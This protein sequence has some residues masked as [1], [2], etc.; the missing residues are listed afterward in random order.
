MHK[1]NWNRLLSADRWDGLD[2]KAQKK[3]GE[4][5]GGSSVHDEVR[6]FQDDTE[7]L[8]YSSAFR[9]MQ[10][11]T[12]V[13]PLPQ[14]DYY[15]TR[16]THSIE[17]AQVGRLIAVAVGRWLAKKH[18]SELPKHVDA[19]DI[20]DIVYTACLAHDIGNPPFGHNGEEAIQSWFETTAKNEV[21]S[22]V[23]D[24]KNEPEKFCDFSSF[25]G[26]AHGFRILTHLQGWRRF[27]GLRLTSATLG[28]FSKYPF[29][30]SDAPKRVAKKKFGY[31]RD[32]DA[33]AS[34]IFESMGMIPH[35]DGG[36]CR[37][38]L[39]FIVEAADDICYHATDI[40]DGVKYRII[41]YAEG[42]DLIYNCTDER[43]RG[44]F[45][46]AERNGKDDGMAYLRSS[47]VATLADACFRAFV[48]NYNEIMMGR[49]SESLISRTP[50]NSQVLKIE[51]ICKEKLY[52]ERSKMEI[53]A[54]GY[55]IIYFLMDSFSKLFDELYK[56][57]NVDFAISGMDKRYVNLFHLIPKETR[58]QINTD[59]SYNMSCILVDY[60]SG[61]SDKY[62]IDLY[63]KLSG[64]GLAVGL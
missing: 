55:H 19:I 20:A 41:D 56:K 43:F 50:Y 62:A 13:H 45:E 18:N 37:H 8:V 59:D 35:N 53:E 2:L 63:R 32:N 48:S 36:F 51:S 10:N 3:R 28:A 52:V 23:C 5:D 39:A 22:F 61:M 40:E 17:V 1:M 31:F 7:R 46:K 64:T 38:P 16:L 49:F 9:R 4:D 15:R 14:S 27:G 33:A 30:S 6:D 47:M 34:T 29:S 11:K 60:I 21:V 26:N 42:R 54:G 44:N 58:D 24:L 57:P 12:Q 25:D